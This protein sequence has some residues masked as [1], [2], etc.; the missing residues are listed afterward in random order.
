M[1]EKA[2]A[3]A[4]RAAHIEAL[5]DERAVVARA[6]DT[7]RAAAVDAE[8][9]LLSGQPKGRRKPAPERG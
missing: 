4:A 5:R 9:A 7:A 8:I 1:D 2:D 3:A 6:G